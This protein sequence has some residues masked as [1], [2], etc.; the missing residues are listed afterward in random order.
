MTT[1][2]YILQQLRT[3]DSWL[4]GD[5][6]SADL[7]ISRAAISKHVGILRQSGYEILTAPNRGYRLQS[8]PDFLF[9]DEVQPL[10]TSTC[11]GQA[12]YHHH[13]TLGSTNKEARQLAEA[14]APEG[15][16]VVS[17]AQTEG[18]GRKGRDW[19]SPSQTGVYATLI[20]RPTLPIEDTPLLTLLTAV[21]T[22]EAI[23]DVTGTS[24]TIKWPNDILL[25]G[26]KVAGILTE[27]SSDVD[28]VEFALIGL[29]LN[30]NTPKN[31]LPKRLLYPAT[32]LAAETG[33]PQSR[34]RILA[35]WLSHF[36]VEYAGLTTGNRQ[37]LLEHWK[38]LAN[39]TGR[40]ASIQR[41][42]DCV[43]GIIKDIDADGA[44]L[45]KTS[46][47]K[48]LRILSGDVSFDDG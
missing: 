11:I 7:D 27:V 2:S 43:S 35:S 38:A 21:A 4:T 16:L 13:L 15:T 10:A 47:N 42:H 39:I 19:I 45:L 46:D 31:A 32:S 9:A 33:S 36:E 20:L 48:I 1:R 14:G 25:N 3:A 28:R 23:K 12:G 40:K 44:L 5:Q 34:Q 30:I 8:A 37:P 26:R 6:L 29:G 18:K 24:P 22:A 17:E 41:V